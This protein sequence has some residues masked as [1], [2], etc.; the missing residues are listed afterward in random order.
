MASESSSSP[1][2]SI[3]VTGPTVFAGWKLRPRSAPRAW[4][5]TS[6]EETREGEVDEW[7][8]RRKSSR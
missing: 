5:Q 7:N 1:R 8:A 2:N 4:T 6:A 3:D